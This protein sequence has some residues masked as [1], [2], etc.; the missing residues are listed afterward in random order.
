MTVIKQMWY[1]ELPHVNN[2]KAYAFVEVLPCC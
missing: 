1:F 2:T